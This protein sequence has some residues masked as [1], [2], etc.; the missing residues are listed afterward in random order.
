MTLP[1]D[2]T[3]RD[4]RLAAADYIASLVMELALIARSQ[5]FDTVGYLLDLV[6]LEAE[7]VA[8]GGNGRG[9]I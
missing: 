9:G 6:R 2:E 7:E 4:A 1:D 5:G 3:G 8:R